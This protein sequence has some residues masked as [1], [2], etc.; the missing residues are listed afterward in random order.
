M[1]LGLSDNLFRT[2]AR[3]IRFEAIPLAGCSQL[4]LRGQC[5][6]F[7]N[8]L[9]PAA[10][11]D[12]ITLPERAR[13]REGLTINERFIYRLADG[14]HDPLSSGIAL[15]HAL[16]IVPEL[17]VRPKLAHQSFAK[18]RPHTHPQ[19]PAIRS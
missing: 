3:V 2:S 13:H 12:Q 7:E 11:C 5:G 16:T 9:G 18:L 17:A 1:W 4:T 19:R 14:R 8:A 15:E 10:D 6:H